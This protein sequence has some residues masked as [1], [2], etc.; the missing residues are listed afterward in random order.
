[1]YSILCDRIWFW[2][3]APTNDPTSPFNLSRD[4]IYGATILLGAG[5]AAL[6]VLSMSMIAYTV[7]DFT[8]SLHHQL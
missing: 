3:K 1:M 7:G 4:S 2:V 8:V 5:G 6:L